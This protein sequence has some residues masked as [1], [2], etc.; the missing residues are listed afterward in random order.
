MTHPSGGDSD[1]DSSDDAGWTVEL[2]PAATDLD[3]ARLGRLLA[4]VV[5]DR[6]AERRLE[7]TPWAGPEGPTTVSDAV[8][9][10]TGDPA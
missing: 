2:R 6:V 1:A 10:D 9:S 4:S 5:L 8:P 7:G 3:Y